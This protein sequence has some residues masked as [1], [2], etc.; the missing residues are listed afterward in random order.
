M[1]TRIRTYGMFTPEGSAAVHGLVVAMR[2][3]G[4]IGAARPH[5]RIR[6]MLE[7]LADS[8]N[9]FAEAADT[10]VCEEVLDALE[11]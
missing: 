5:Y 2:D 1:K 3:M 11:V 9:D 4:Y 6:K 7:S 10:A 8:N